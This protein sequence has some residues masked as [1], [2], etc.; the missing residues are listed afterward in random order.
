[1]TNLA[2][3]VF[4]MSS[5]KD[6]VVLV[7]EIEN[8][9]HHSVLKKVWTVIERAAEQFNVQVFATTHSYE[10]VTAAQAALKTDNLRYLRLDVVDSKV[11]CVTYTPEAIEAAIRHD[12]EVR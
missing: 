10:C 7:D 8:G 11:R 1:M 3:L 5:A 12:L 6:G 9:F 4:A 2:R